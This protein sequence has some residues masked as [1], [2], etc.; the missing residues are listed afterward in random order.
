M[1]WAVSRM[2]QLR[3]LGVEL[4]ATGAV[5]FLTTSGAAQDLSGLQELEVFGIAGDGY[6][7]MVLENLLRQASALIRLASD[8]R[9]MA[10]GAKGRLHAPAAC[11]AA[12]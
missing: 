10:S 11:Q 12:S 9:C 6:C 5:Q 2:R 4:I 3:K 7:T 8:L 1:R